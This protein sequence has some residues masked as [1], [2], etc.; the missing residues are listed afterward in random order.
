MATQSDAS[1]K[2]VLLRLNCGLRAVSP[3][4]SVEIPTRCSEQIGGAAEGRSQ[5]LVVANI[6]ASLLGKIANMSVNGHTI[7]A[8]QTAQ[9]VDRLGA[10]P[11]HLQ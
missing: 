6:D 4:P 1:E 3:H 11:F 2:F 8:N 5:L 9:V 10:N 7:D